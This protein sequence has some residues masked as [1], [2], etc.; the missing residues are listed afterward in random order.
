VDD[1][2][3]PRTVHARFVRSPM[4]HARVKGVETAA[5]RAAAGVVAVM[6]GADID[7]GP[8]TPPLATPGVLALPQDVL[9]RS[10]VRFAG[11]PFAV[12]LA[13]SPYAAEDAADLVAADF[14]PLPVVVDP[15]QAVLTDAPP[16]HAG[17][18]NVTFERSFTAGDVDHALATAEVRFERRLRSHR[19]AAAPLEPR[20]LLV[21][22]EGDG[23]C[24]RASTQAPYM[25]RDVLAEL[26]DLEPDLVRVVGVSVGGGFGQKAHVYI[27]D[28]AVAWLALHLG[29]PVKWIEDRG[30]NLLA[31]GHARDQIIDV[32]AA[33][34]AQGRLLALDVDLL[35]DVGAYGPYAHGHIIEA[36][37]TP[38][39]IPGPYRLPAY[40]Y[41]TRAVCTNK[42]PLGGYRGV[43][44][45]LATF[46]HE[47]VMDVIAAE[48]ALDKVEVRR[49]NLLTPRDLPY[50]SLGG[51]RYDSGDYP[52]ALSV[53]A[54]RIGAATFEDER[55]EARAAGRLIG[56]GFASFTEF[57][58]PNAAVFRARGMLAVRGD[59]AAHVALDADG[60]ATVWTTLPP[61][62][63]GSL[64]TFAQ[65]TADA[66]G[67]PLEAVNVAHADTGVGG[68]NGTGTAMSRS[69]ISGGGAIMLASAEITRRLREDAAD[70]LEAA[71]EDMIVVDGN[72]EVRGAPGHGLTIAGL[73]R[74]AMPDRYRVSSAFDPEAVTYAYA[75]HACC[76]EIDP[77]TA[78]VW[79]L[80]YVV[81]EDCGR[82]INPAI[83]DGQ[84]R[85]GVAQGIGGALHE[86]HHYDEDGQLQTASFMDYLVPTAREIPGVQV[87]HLGVPTTSPTGARGVGEGGAVGS[88][89][90]V[91][92]AVS[93]A[94]GV[95]CN[96]LPITP[97]RVWQAL[98]RTADR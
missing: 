65:I 81:A 7:V 39:M 12:V 10:V 98:R 57:T 8:L 42:V 89:A 92:N 52:A 61:I 45:P 77:D 24:V 43:G 6:V 55:R 22:P 95:E 2:R 85:G 18:P 29:R 71:P 48:L 16:V 5:A 3:L 88:P 32:R 53:A 27:E 1:I 38:G 72:V 35:V 20:G 80:R 4:A 25:L 46:V 50:T 62:G 41:R 75:T 87:V 15:E 54:D 9:A 79:I 78:G 21:A 69:A 33:A 83:V 67:L 93:D 34:D 17:L 74:R 47:R 23:L 60:R 51:H 11:E 59:D 73:V 37:G 26:L 13:D 90:A 91:A 19:S 63:Q 30:E 66:I 14:D 44:M 56:L 49:R 40:R 31:S 82:I 28:V 68:L 76:V 96:E 84:V 36:A 86:L 64:T 97:E 94:L 58:A 70:E